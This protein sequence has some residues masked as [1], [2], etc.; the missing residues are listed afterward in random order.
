MNRGSISTLWQGSA[1]D[2]WQNG[3]AEDQSGGAERA[4]P[5]VTIRSA[6]DADLPAILTIY[7]DA[8]VNTTAIWNDHLSDLEGRRVWWQQRIA[9]G[10]PVLAAERDGQCVGYATYGPFRPNDGYRQSR[11]LS[12]YV[13]KSHR[14][15]GIASALLQAL[16]DYARAHDVHVLIGGIEA[17]NQA[18]IALHAKHGFKQAAYL[19][20]VGRKFERWLDLVLMQ[21]ILD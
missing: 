13:S 11:E 5:D 10:F 3:L 9:D 20:Q 6:E 8:V 12:V 16:E 1:A 4:M 21:K 14:G 15:N 19:E 7:N 18:S 17:G 2:R